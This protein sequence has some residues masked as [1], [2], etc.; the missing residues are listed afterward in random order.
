MLE[1]IA[2]PMD[3]GKEMFCSLGE[4]HDSLEIDNLCTCSSYSRKRLCEQFEVM[5]MI[6][7]V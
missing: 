2:L 3:V 5:L 4:I 7:D 6:S 1:G